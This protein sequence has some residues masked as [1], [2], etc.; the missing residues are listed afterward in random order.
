MDRS[1]RKEFSRVEDPVN[2]SSNTHATRHTQ[3]FYSILRCL[4][5]RIR[6]VLMQYDK[7][8]A[9]ASRQLKKHKENYPTHDLELVAIV[10]ALKIWR[11]YLIRNKY[12]IFTNHKR[13]KYIFTQPN[14]NLR[15]RRWLELIKDYD[16]SV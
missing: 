13:L 7:V 8:V 11:H 5:T 1:L 12:E 3:K 4:T 14:L 6:C 10:H 9:Y 15:Q 16:L 2:H